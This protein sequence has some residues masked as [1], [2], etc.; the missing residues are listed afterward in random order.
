MQFLGGVVPPTTHLT[1]WRRP[2]V[3]RSPSSL[4][5]VLVPQRAA[6]RATAIS[7]R[8]RMCE[9]AFELSLNSTLSHSA[10]F[11][12]RKMD[13]TMREYTLVTLPAR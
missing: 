3:G 13:L 10:D 5:K 6:H 12:T 2:A 11:F 9:N 1:A 7:H 4:P 8:L